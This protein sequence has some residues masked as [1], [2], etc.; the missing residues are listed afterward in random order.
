VSKENVSYHSKDAYIQVMDGISRKTL[1]F[2]ENALLSEFRLSKGRTL[3]SHRHPE[4]Q[5]GYL[6]SG[7]IT[8]YIDGEAYDMRSGDSWAIP[9]DMEHSADIM[10]DSIA[11]EVFAPV[12]KDYLP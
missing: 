3:P 10:E 9:G 7:H 1:A 8:L 5:V 12:R 11:I 2:G 4:E 6:V